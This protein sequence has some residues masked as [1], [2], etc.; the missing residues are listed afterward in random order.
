MIEFEDEELDDYIELEVVV[1]TYDEHEVYSAW[2][3]HVQGILKLPAPGLWARDAQEPERRERAMIL[4]L[5]HDDEM[6]EGLLVDV[7]DSRG[8]LWSAPL[9]HIRLVHPD[10]DEALVLA[11]WERWV[12]TRGPDF[13]IEI[14]DEEE[15]NW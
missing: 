13:G 1:D 15:Q 11:A 3:S 2:V 14:G 10:F 6:I 12:E 8:N 9:E 5:G 7:E 4:A